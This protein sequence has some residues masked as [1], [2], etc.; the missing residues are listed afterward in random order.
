MPLQRVFCFSVI[1]TL[2]ACNLL[3]GKCTYEIRSTQASGQLNQNGAMF[4]GAELT[5]SEQRGSLQ[6]QSLNWLV[7][8]TDLKGHVTS[9]SFKDSSNP[10]QLL[11]DLPLASADRPEISQGTAAS[12]EGANLAG[13]HDT[14]AAGRGVVELKT[15]LPS[16]PTATVQ[17]APTNVGDWIRPY[18]SRRPQ[19]H[20]GLSN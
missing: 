2:S 6:G 9:A 12:V 14:I 16:P 4:A 17:L 8:S 10:S 3:N 11:L 5:L 13:F 18:C 20:R 15:D 1:L 7:T 19:D